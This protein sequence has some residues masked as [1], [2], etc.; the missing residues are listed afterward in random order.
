MAVIPLGSHGRREILFLRA[1]P[2]K[3]PY[4]LYLTGVLRVSVVN[5]WVWLIGVGDF[6]YH[7]ATHVDHQAHRQGSWQKI[8]YRQIGKLPYSR[9]NF[10]SLDANF[11]HTQ[12][13]F[14]FRMNLIDEI[15]RPPRA[16]FRM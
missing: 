4:W 9:K 7:D 13:H 1:C 5:I 2:V 12:D 6:G 11:R 10:I 14:A 3:C 8:R 16:V 15:V